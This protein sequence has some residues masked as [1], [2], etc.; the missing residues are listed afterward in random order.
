[1]DKAKSIKPIRS[2]TPP[3]Q[4]DYQAFELPSGVL[5]VEIGC[6]VGLHPIQYQKQNP[7]RNLVAIE[8][9]REKFEKFERRFKNHGSPKNL[10]PVHA[11]GIS[12]VS[13]QLPENSV[14][15]FFFLYPNPN[16][17]PGGLNKRW[18]AMPFMHKVL[19]VLKPGGELTLATNEKFYRDEALEYFLEFWGLKL[20]EE[21]TL[22]KDF[23]H[24]THFEKK[25]LERDEHCYNLVFTN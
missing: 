25:Y 13:Q 14:D 18:H 7:K 12:W 10:F 21:T 3:P 4:E 24:R 1:M 9:T 22:E 19:E 17:K 20:K 16:P 5:D 6:G 2:F 8:H 23:P 11:N 15:R